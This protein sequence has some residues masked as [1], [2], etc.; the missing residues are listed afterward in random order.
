MYVVHCITSKK[1]ESQVEALFCDFNLW[2]SLIPLCEQVGAFCVVLWCDGHHMPGTL[3]FERSKS[4][5][6]R[7]SAFPQNILLLWRQ[8][9]WLWRERFW[10]S[11]I[12]CW[13]STSRPYWSL[14][15]PLMVLSLCSFSSTSW[16]PLLPL[17][18]VGPPA[19]WG[20]D[21]FCCVVRFVMIRFSSGWPVGPAPHHL[22]RLKNRL[23]L[24]LAGWKF[25]GKTD[26]VWNLP[27]MFCI[28]TEWRSVYYEVTKTERSDEPTH[29]QQ[30]W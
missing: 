8:Q 13:W 27:C 3:Q 10:S 22:L 1:I 26:I 7:C 16:Q 29:F 5:E 24:I 6:H 25:Q 17:F 11:K 28:Y 19:H 12:Q 18:C 2:G 21:F 20:R 9:L 23:T 30:R 14:V 4:Q 15:A